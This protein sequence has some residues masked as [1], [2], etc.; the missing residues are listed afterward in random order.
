MLA[1]V[2][3][4]LSLGGFVLFNFAQYQ[5]WSLFADDANPVALRPGQA[6]RINHK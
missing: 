6:A 5:G 1:R 3:M 4:I 2:A